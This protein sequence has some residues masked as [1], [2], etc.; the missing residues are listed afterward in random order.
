MAALHV[1]RL[2]TFGVILVLSLVILGLSGYIYGNTTSGFED[3]YGDIYSVQVHYVFAALGIAVG[4]L[5]LITV[6]PM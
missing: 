6:G 4:V 5:T 3:F 1:Y 2:V